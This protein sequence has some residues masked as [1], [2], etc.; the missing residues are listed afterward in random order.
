MLRYTAGGEGVPNDDYA[1]IVNFSGDSEEAID[2][3]GVAA[4]LGQE[5]GAAVVVVA[6]KNGVAGWVQKNRG[7]EI[8]K[9]N[10]TKLLFFF[11]FRVLYDD[12]SEITLGPLQTVI[13]NFIEV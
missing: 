6:D 11:F 2:L 9:I 1:T 5:W 10:V 13:V 7:G 3:E 4:A 12:L 8:R